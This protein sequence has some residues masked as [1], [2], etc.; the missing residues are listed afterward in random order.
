MT[1]AQTSTTSFKV[2]LLQAVHNF[3]PTTPDTFKI[4]CT[5]QRQTLARTRLYIQQLLK[6]WA[7]ATRLGATRL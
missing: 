3:G 7:Q 1:I 6:L 4:A 2:E 5:R